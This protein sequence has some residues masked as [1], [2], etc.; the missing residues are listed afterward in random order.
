MERRL[1]P[2]RR[3][4]YSVLLSL[5]VATGALS[6]SLG[7]A[8]SVTLADDAYHYPAWAG[9]RHD[10]WFTEWWYFNLFDAAAGVQAIFSYFITN[11]ANVRGLEQVQM[12]ASV[13]TADGV[14][15]AIDLYPMSALAASDGQ[16]DVSI[17]TNI[18][19]VQND[20]TYL[21]SGASQDQ[22]LAWNLVYTPESEPW[23]A[24]DRMTIGRLPWEQMSWLVEMPRAR[25]KGE[26]TVDGHS[27]AIDA[28]GYHDHNWGE[29]IP[30][31]GLWNWAQYSDD[32][33]NLEVGDF[34]GSPIGVVSLDLDGERT[35]FGPDQYQLTHTRWGWD[36]QN[37]IFYPTESR[38]RANNGTLR[39][40]VDLRVLQ[41]EPLRGNLPLPLKDLIIYEQTADY[42][43]QVWAW[44][45]S[46]RGSGGSWRA[47]ARI[48]GPGFKEWTAKHY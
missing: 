1:H 45:P 16:A 13:Y 23:L 39:L 33:L 36:A 11:P 19:R 35:V 17:G 30:T 18:A 31:D 2:P 24:A 6:P 48:Q 14:V 10:T 47:K 38:L 5:A 28:P 15:S 46:A 29:W 25:V 7:A 37:R 21:V 26:V 41:D 43:G 27:Y 32:R 44:Q 40:D 20:G 4:V 8:T 42:Q 22:R 3:S 34:I 12:V 9:G